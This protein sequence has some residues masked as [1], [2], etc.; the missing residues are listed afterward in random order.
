MKP[1]GIF[2][3]AV[4]VILMACVSGQ[5]TGRENQGKVPEEKSSCDNFLLFP[6]HLFRKYISGADGDRCGMYPSCSTYALNSFEKHGLLTG[7]IM[8]CDRL[9]R[10][11]RDETRLSPSVRQ[12]GV[13]LTYDPV[14]HNDFWWS[15]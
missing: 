11:G 15:K 10:C 14:S 8:T 12:N 7:W 4:V 1:K 5:V 6:I 13:R 9:M 3:T 2:I